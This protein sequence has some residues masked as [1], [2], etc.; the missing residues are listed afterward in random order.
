MDS[1]AVIAA[2]DSELAR[3]KSRIS[4]LETALRSID[5]SHSILLERTATSAASN[6]SLSAISEAESL[7]KKVSEPAKGN[8]ELRKSAEDLQDSAENKQLDELPISGRRL[9]H[10]TKTRPS[11]RKQ[12]STSGPQDHIHKDDSLQRVS[13]DGKP[14]DFPPANPESEFKRKISMIGGVN[15]LMGLN[16]AAM[17]GGLKRTVPGTSNVLPSSVLANASKEGGNN[18]SNHKSGSANSLIADNKELASS[19]GREPTSSPKESTPV[20]ESTREFS[21][22]PKRGLPFADQESSYVKESSKGNSNPRPVSTPPS[23]SVEVNK[24]FKSSSP[25]ISL[26]PASMALAAQAASAAVA[27]ATASPPPS[28]SNSR[29]ASSAV[30][31]PIY[32]SSKQT[33]TSVSSSATPA[34]SGGNGLTIAARTGFASLRKPNDASLK[35]GVPS[36][37]TLAFSSGPGTV[38]KGGNSEEDELRY[39]IAE[40]VGNTS[41]KDKSKDLHSLLKDGVLLCQL[42]NGL[43]ISNPIKVNCGKFAFNHMG[44][45]NNYLNRADSDFGVG[46]SFRF[47]P[48]DLYENAN[49]GKVTAHL[50]AL[51]D[52]SRK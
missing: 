37:T 18:S 6:F 48:A 20:K 11:P 31:N 4:E 23:S 40:K 25:I 26:R 3:L 45:I 16:P 27:S 38:S 47:D 9:N 22:P 19:H 12:R 43:G 42:L 41:L 15:P 17:L 28:K 29:P 5:P 21:Q 39:W 14:F 24:D 35:P 50:R 13:E 30:S 49:L 8:E 46:K 2:Q 34:L 7:R 36:E 44:N 32:S 10:I 51:K 33:P 52:K 1:S